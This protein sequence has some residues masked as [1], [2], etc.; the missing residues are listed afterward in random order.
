MTYSRDGIEGI[1]GKSPIS[2]KGEGLRER[3]S[4]EFMIEEVSC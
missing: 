2:L 4:K 3:S 1:R